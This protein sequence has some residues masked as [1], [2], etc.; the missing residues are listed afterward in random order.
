MFI[1]HQGGRSCGSAVV[2]GRFPNIHNVVA[3]SS[4]V[5]IYALLKRI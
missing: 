4:F 2:K 1:S 3:N 5:A